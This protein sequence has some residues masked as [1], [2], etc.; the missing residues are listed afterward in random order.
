MDEETPAATDGAGVAGGPVGLGAVDPATG[1]HEWNEQRTTPLGAVV[2]QNVRRIR[3][4]RVL[5]QHELAQIWHRHGLKW[6]RSKIAA[7]ETGNRPRV[8]FGELGV[9][10][11]SLG[12][13]LGDLLQGEGRVSLDPTPTRIS[14]HD[15]RQLAAGRP[16]RFEYFLEDE[17]AL[18]TE[19]AWLDQRLGSE[20]SANA[21]VE[22]AKRLGVHPNLVV[23][24]AVALFDGRTLTVERDRRAERLGAGMPKAERQ[25]HRGHITR[26]LSEQ[27]EDH[28]QRSDEVES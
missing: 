10:A 26:E 1:L 25:A 11:L 6:A 19:R 18:R 24:A 4:A 3:E 13:P 17:E 16:A 8:D 27:I 7:L 14:L 21:D 23:A 2:G 12:V 5:T 15:L 28:L 20:Q 9:M 22:L